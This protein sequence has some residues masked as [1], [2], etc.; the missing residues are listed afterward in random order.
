MTLPEE[1]EAEAPTAVTRFAGRS[2]GRRGRG[3]R[4]GSR[5]SHGARP[6]LVS[7][8]SATRRRG[9][10]TIKRRNGRRTPD[11]RTEAPR[12]RGDRSLTS[13]PPRAKPKARTIR[14]FP[15]YWKEHVR[16]ARR[17][18]PR[19]PDD[20]PRTS[21]TSLALEP[22]KIVRRISHELEERGRSPLPDSKCCRAGHGE[23]IARMERRGIRRLGGEKRLTAIAI[24][25]RARLLHG[26][27]SRGRPR[28]LAPRSSGRQG[29]NS[30]SANG[31]KCS[32]ADD[33]EPG[34]AGEVT[35]IS[36][37]EAH[38]VGNTGIEAGR[39]PRYRAPPRIGRRSSTRTSGPRGA[40]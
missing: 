28:Q 38:H 3:T 11:L 17:E 25:C 9:A 1:Q 21:R 23:E 29:A 31:L 36:A 10:L 32:R 8:S 37:Q 14:R 20:P 15:M 19:T 4:R 24:R 39:S 5:R 2:V 7:F 13:V 16:G 12:R 22:P 34:R 40:R 30:P 27:A 6:K 35:M 18:G 26:A 33:V